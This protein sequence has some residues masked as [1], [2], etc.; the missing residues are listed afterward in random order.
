MW[1]I[2]YGT[3]G[4]LEAQ[5]TQNAEHL[6]TGTMQIMEHTVVNESV[7]TVYKQHQRNSLQICVQIC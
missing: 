4:Q 1:I 6:T 3:W 7:H 2:S 5:F